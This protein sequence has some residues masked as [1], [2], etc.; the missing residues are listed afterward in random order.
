MLRPP[1]RLSLVIM[2]EGMVS[3][4]LAF[5]LGQ[6]FTELFHHGSAMIGGLWAAISAVVV[7]QGT[8]HDTRKAA[9]LR[10]AGTLVGALVC[11]VYLSLLPFS[12]LGMALCVGIT[13]MLCYVCNIFDYARLAC[14]T[15]LVISVVGHESPDVPPFL[16][17]FLRFME[18]TIGV[19]VT[20]GTVYILHRF[21]RRTAASS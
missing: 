18:A 4:L 19:V 17:A 15:V 1:D 14:A 11:A 5:V 12:L 7:L 20:V 2:L 10:V 3:V 21:A 6:R 8:L 9:F 16:N 13:I